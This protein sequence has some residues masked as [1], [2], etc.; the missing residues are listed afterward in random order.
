VGSNGHALSA[1]AS[2]QAAGFLTV[3]IRPPTV[4]ALGGFMAAAATRAA[5]IKVA[6]RSNF[7]VHIFSASAALSCAGFLFNPS[8]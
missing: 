6:S 2:L 7:T 8:V 1:S 5:A 3:A 4:A